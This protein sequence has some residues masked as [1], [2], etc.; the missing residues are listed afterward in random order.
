MAVIWC[1]A[2]QRL[3]P[4]VT[5]G[6]ESEVCSR[7]GAPC[8][9]GTAA[10]WGRDWCV[11]LRDW[12]ESTTARGNISIPRVALDD[13]AVAHGQHPSFQ[14]SRRPEG[15]RDHRRFG[16]YGSR[17]R[18]AWG[19]G[20]RCRASHEGIASRV[21]PREIEGASNC[22]TKPYLRPSATTHRSR[23]S[24]PRHLHASGP[25]RTGFRL[26]CYCACWA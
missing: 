23:S 2:I 7:T 18:L 6:A 10:V 11:W 9:T 5:D 17:G 24:Y 16:P 26:S 3:P 19:P 4:A 22:A 20:L 25:A 12:D 13:N 8:I 21:V 15:K 1:G 14:R